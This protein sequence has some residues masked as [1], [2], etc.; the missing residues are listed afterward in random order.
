M[1][2]FVND[3]LISNKKISQPPL[4]NGGI[5][6][7]DNDPTNTAAVPGQP[8]VPTSNTTYN[9]GSNYAAN[10]RTTEVDVLLVG[11]GGSSGAH[12]GG[13]G[14]GGGVIHRPGMPVSGG[15]TYPIGVGSGAPGPPGNF[16]TGGN[17][18]D[19]TVFGLTAKGGGHA[20]WNP[21][22]GGNPGGSGGGGG[23]SGGPGSQPSQPGDSGNY[24]FGSNGYSPGPGGGGGAGSSGGTNGGNGKSVGGQFPGTFGGGGCGSGGSGGPGGGGNSNGGGTNGLGGGG[25]KDLGGSGGNGV[26]KIYVPAVSAI[27]A[28]PEDKV[29]NGIWGVKTQY[30]SR[31]QDIWPT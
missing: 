2:R 25:G 21:G 28:V 20:G 4:D 5:V 19:T 18:G 29:A 15:T 30:S 1:S 27:P 11:G 3:N 7:P 22:P 23:P 6:G 13:G 16:S 17:G 14:G 8:A 31:V 26:V 9:S 12:Y 10:P 24:G